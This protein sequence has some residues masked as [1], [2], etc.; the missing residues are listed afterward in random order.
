ME[1]VVASGRILVQVCVP[2]GGGARWSFVAVH[3]LAAYSRILGFVLYIRPPPDPVWRRFRS[4]IK[5]KMK[6]TFHAT[7]PVSLGAG[8]PGPLPGD[9]PAAGGRLPIQAISGAV[10]DPAR[11]RLVHGA[12]VVGVQEGLF[13]NFLCVLGFSVRS[14]I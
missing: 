1:V 6:V 2:F 3:L 12:G 10:A 7:M 5:V 4:K 13:C 14:W 8:P 11:H 9:F